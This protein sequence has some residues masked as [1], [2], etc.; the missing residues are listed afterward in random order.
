VSAPADE[1]RAIGA[2]VEAAGE[3]PNGAVKASTADRP[4]VKVAIGTNENG[5]AI[6]ED[7]P[8]LEV[9]RNALRLESL[10]RVVQ[11]G[12][13]GALF[14]LELEDE[15]LIR[16]GTIKDLRDPNKVGDVIAERPWP[17]ETPPRYTRQ[18]WDPIVEALRAIVTLEPSITPDDETREWLSDYLRARPTVTRDLSDPTERREAIDGNGISG[19]AGRSPV[20]PFWAAD[21]LYVYLPD[22][23]IYVRDQRRERL[24]VTMR[25]VAA[26]LDRLG[27]RDYELKLSDAEV[28]AAAT[29]D[30]GTATRRRYRRSPPGEFEV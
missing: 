7:R 3:S 23:H 30:P 17:Q 13:S 14:E 25:D 15:T 18:K 28:G 16:I 1:L 11:R 24:N 20:D 27:F 2:E 10:R 22:F 8:A 12:E 5:Q 9:A 29:P 6:Y 19:N 21:Q 4:T 26:R